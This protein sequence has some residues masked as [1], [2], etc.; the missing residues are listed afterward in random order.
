[1]LAIPALLPLVLL[2]YW[3]ARVLFTQWYQRRA[4]DFVQADASS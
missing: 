1:L 3:L 4:P 2:L